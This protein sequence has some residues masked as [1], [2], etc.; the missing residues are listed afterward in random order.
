MKKL[1]IILDSFSC[2][3]KEE[4]KEYGYG[5]ISLKI[6]ID[7]NLYE[8]GITLPHRLLIE[9]INDDSK[10]ITSTPSLKNIEEIVAEFSQNYD[11]VLYLGISSKLSSTFNNVNIIGKNYKNFHSLDNNLVGNQYIYFAKYAQKRF[12]ETQDIELIIEE[13]K[14]AFKE[15]YTLIIPPNLKR[16]IGGGRL[17]GVKKLFLQ[18]LKFLPI[19]IYDNE[20][21]VKVYAL[22][23]T[24]KG[25]I[26]TVLE[27]I[28]E[29]SKA[30][31][32]PVFQMVNGIDQL[33]EKDVKELANSMGIK[34][35]E[36]CLASALI[37]AH[38]G[39]KGFAISLRPT[40]KEK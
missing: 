20:A 40:L 34:F 37:M 31:N 10:V 15:T 22:K 14:Q 4:L 24:F 25:A 36:E 11:E 35:E 21:N 12:E 13:I 29:S 18:A 7:G 1:G 32:E 38:I 9:K 28:L 30:I 23:R 2:K 8:D 5:F 19:I 26:K 27:E 17:K 3:S 39:S 16:L 6:E 33:I